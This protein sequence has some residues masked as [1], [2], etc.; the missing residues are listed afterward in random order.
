MTVVNQQK[1][2]RD[3]I[4]T[5]IDGCLKLCDVFIHEEPENYNQV[6]TVFP[7]DIHK[8][9]CYATCNEYVAKLRYPY[10]S[11]NDINALTEELSRISVIL[12]GISIVEQNICL[13]LTHDPKIGVIMK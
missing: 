8:T 2:M 9:H 6:V 1:E 7:H 13:C 3:T 4:T 5:V 12:H 10:L 11:I